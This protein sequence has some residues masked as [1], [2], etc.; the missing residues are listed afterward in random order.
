LICLQ[1]YVLALLFVRYLEK[2]RS[3]LGKYF[4]HPQKY[5]LQYTYDFEYLGSC[6]KL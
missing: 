2:T 5:A 4:L 1:W 6:W 3:N